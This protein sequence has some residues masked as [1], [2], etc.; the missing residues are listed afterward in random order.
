VTKEE[1]MGGVWAGRNICGAE[2]RCRV[3]RDEAGDE[4]FRSVDIVV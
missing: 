1:W 2:F 3:V 4:V